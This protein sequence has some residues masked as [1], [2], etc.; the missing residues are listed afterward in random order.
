ML[1]VRDR[2]LPLL[3]LQSD[4]MQVDNS[5][6]K[7]KAEQYPNVVATARRTVKQG[8]GKSC[9]YIRIRKSRPRLSYQ[10]L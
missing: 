4:S 1:N 3:Q 6:A 9:S 5:E 10:D 8:T 2:C 7:C